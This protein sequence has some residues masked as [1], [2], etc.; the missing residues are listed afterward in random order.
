[1]DKPKEQ[2]KLIQYTIEVEALVPATLKYKVLAYTPEEALLSLHKA[3]PIESPK[4][5]FA[6]MKRLSAKIF[7]YGTSILKL[8][9]RF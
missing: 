5:K 4:L 9:K 1:M 7:N 8:S 3:T 6:G 2:P